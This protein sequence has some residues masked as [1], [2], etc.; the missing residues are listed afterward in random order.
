VGKSPRGGKRRLVIKGGIENG[1]NDG[2][3]TGMPVENPEKK[4]LKGHTLR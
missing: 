2:R 3:V 1:G 4:M